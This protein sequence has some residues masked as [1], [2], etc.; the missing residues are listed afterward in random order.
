MNNKLFA[1]RLNQ[2]LDE[3]DFP[4]LQDERIEAF[5][6]LFDIPRFKSETVLKGQILPDDPLLM[7]IAQELEVELEWLLGK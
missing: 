2:A 5:A 1:E 4:S 3:I 6:K 7:D